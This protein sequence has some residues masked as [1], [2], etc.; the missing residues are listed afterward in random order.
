MIWSGSRECTNPNA[1]PVRS[2]TNMERSMDDLINQ[3]VVI[4]FFYFVLLNLSKKADEK[5]DCSRIMEVVFLSEL[6][7]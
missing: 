3:E 5:N 1:N 2:I 6:S 7:D 4:L